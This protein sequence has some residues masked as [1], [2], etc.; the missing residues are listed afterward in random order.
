MAH[1]VKKWE[2]EEYGYFYQERIVFLLK[3]S[4]SKYRTGPLS[5]IIKQ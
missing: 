1:A 3:R 4:V 5:L 2:R